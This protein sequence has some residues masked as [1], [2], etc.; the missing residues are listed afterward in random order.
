MVKRAARIGVEAG[1]LPQ[2]LFNALG[3]ANLPAVCVE[4]RHMRA[5]T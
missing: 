2:W 3:E 1:P 5:V 4:T